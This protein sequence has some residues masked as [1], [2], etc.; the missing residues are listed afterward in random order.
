MKKLLIATTLMSVLALTG[1]QQIQNSAQNL[2]QQGEQTLN[3][4]SQQANG[5]KTQ[6]LETKAK[7]D[8]K[9]QQVVNAVGAVNN[10]LK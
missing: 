10:V 3:G 7:Y 6:V 2:R 1:C 5:L 9:S 8:E 4:F